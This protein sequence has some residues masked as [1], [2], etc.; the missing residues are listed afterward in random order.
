MD[1]GSVTIDETEVGLRELKDDRVGSGAG[2]VGVENRLTQR[3]Q[4]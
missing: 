4:P 2:R 1:V 3:A